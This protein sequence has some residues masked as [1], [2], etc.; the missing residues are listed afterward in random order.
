MSS[1]NHMPGPLT[2]LPVVGMPGGGSC[3]IDL[4]AAAQL[5]ICSDI[6]V[7]VHAGDVVDV[8]PD[9][10][11]VTPTKPL[12]A[13]DGTDDPPEIIEQ[14]FATPTPTPTGPPKLP[15]IVPVPVVSD[16]N[17]GNGGDGGNGGSGGFGDPGGNGGNGGNGGFNAPGGDGGDG[18][19]GG[20]GGDSTLIPIHIPP[21]AEASQ[22]PQAIETPDEPRQPDIHN[23]PQKPH[24]PPWFH[25]PHPHAGTDSPP[26]VQSPA[27]PV[28]LTSTV[29]SPPE[30]STEIPV[31]P[32]PY[33]VQPPVHHVDV[34]PPKQPLN[35][36]PP[37][38][39]VVQA[40]QPM[41]AYCEKSYTSIDVTEIQGLDEH[42]F[43]LYLN[44]LGVGE[45]GLNL[46]D[47]LGGLLGHKRAV[48][49]TSDLAD[50]NGVNTMMPLKRDLLGSLLSGTPLSGAGG[51]NVLGSSSPLSGTGPS[52]PIGG[53]SSAAPSTKG[54][55]TSKFASVKKELVHQ[56]RVKCGVYLP[57]AAS[58]GGP[59]W[60]AQF[61]NEI[62][63]TASDHDACLQM[64]E[65]QAIKSADQGVLMECLGAAY[66]DE[67]GEC[68][69]WCG[70]KKEN[71]FLPVET[72]PT[73]TIAGSGGDDNVGVG[74]G[75]VGGMNG[76]SAA[77]SNTGS[78]DDHRK[79]SGST[80]V[81]GNENR[82]QMVY[83]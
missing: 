43:D 8:H 60:P 44:L 75:N 24:L 14:P 25:H 50:E 34:P 74:N 4:T 73:T 82:F 5:S 32:T 11:C 83:L 6:N 10:I 61:P 23:T 15:V 51:S 28:V 41:P 40:P 45:L 79:G 63:T 30:Q 72:L 36:Q 58:T 67:G 1:L 18:G 27:E 16:G 54:I 71:E 21:P 37:T 69:Y 66:A 17:G 35:M 65:K 38:E 42:D 53:D 56:Y 13:D 70:D 55:D 76:N 81:K 22:P 2:R 68:R 19:N 3:F 33:P 7:R 46:H 77:E 52:L 47:V 31:E 26:F 78:I 59:I 29:V 64:C 39:P 62:L 49:D 48:S 57:P 9:S 20:N 80:N 12:P